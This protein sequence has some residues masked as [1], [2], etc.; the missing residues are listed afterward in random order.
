MYGVSSQVVRCATSVVFQISSCQMYDVSCVWDL[1]L[2]DVRRQLCF[3]SPAVRCTTSVVF[4]IA[5]CQITTSVVFQISSCQIFEVNCVWY[6]QL[7]DVRLQLSDVRRQLCLRSSPVG[8]STLGAFDISSC[9]MYDVSCVWDIQLSNYNV[10]WFWDIRLSDYDVSCIWDPQLSNVRRQ[11]CLRYPDVRCTTSV[12]FEISSCQMYDV[13]CIWDSQL[14]DYDVSCV[15]DIQMS[16]VR[17]QLCLSSSAVRCAAI[18]LWLYW[19]LMYDSNFILT[20]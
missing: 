7:S 6:L 13:S 10:S 2:S 8:C 12:L 14:S 20:L 4:E 9:Q 17:R 15:W 5:N 11:L 19:V 18:V 1:Q 3:R 16:D